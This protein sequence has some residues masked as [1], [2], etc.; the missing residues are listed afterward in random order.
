MRKKAF[1]GLVIIAALCTAVISSSGQMKQIGKFTAGGVE[2]ANKLLEAYIAPWANALGTSLSGGWYNTA[3]VHKLGGFDITF[4]MN[5]GLVPKTDKTFDLST[6]GLSPEAS[7]SSNTAPTAAGKAQ[8]GPTMTYDIAGTQVPLY[9]TPKGTGLGFIPS[10]MVQVGVGLIKGTEIDGRYMPGV[11]LGN[12]GSFGL[13]GIGLK[14]DLLQWLPLAEKIPALNVSIQGGYTKLS[15]KKDL[16]F[17]PGDVG[18]VPA[19]VLTSPDISFT[20]QSLDLVIKSFTVNLLASVNLPVVSFYGGL[21]IA[22]TKTDL[23]MKGYYPIPTIDD[24]PAHMDTFGELVVTDESVGDPDPISFM[25]KNN[26]G[27]PTKPR[28]N[29]GIRFKLGPITIHGDYTKANYSNIT[30]GLG[31]SIR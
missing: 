4:T 17:Q 3:K 31:V 10:P 20:G 7:Y 14:H 30:A 8:P 6:L 29:I 16:S 18:V 11:D 27:S 25:I 12:Y 26:E 28:L 23:G 15:Y 19:N 9:Q 1:K 21:G 24:N 13:W 22:N 5:M 2:D